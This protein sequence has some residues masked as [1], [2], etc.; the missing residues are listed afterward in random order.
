MESRLLYWELSCWRLIPVERL[1]I[2]KDR[3]QNDFMKVSNYMARQFANPTGLFGRLVI[4]NMLN[5]ANIESNALVLKMLDLKTES[6]VLEAGFGGGDLLLKISRTVK[7]GRL[8]G[9]EMSAPMLRA[10]DKKLSRNKVQ[11]NIHLH[12][13]TIESL[14]FEDSLFDRVCSVNTVY[15][16]S[17]LSQG[18]SEFSRIIQPGG[19]FVLGFGSDKALREAGYEKRGFT[20][21]SPDE[22]S[23]TL[24]DTGFDNIEQKT[25]ARKKRGPFYVLKAKRT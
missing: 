7:T 5:R 22:I 20:L 17:D 16:W 10:L 13:G 11:S 1:S 23:N 24:K 19:Y 6:R 21:Y 8:D 2:N 9:V 25:I 15:F 12:Q 14:P 18:L 4:G 3:I